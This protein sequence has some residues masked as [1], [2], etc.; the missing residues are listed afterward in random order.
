MAC[1]YQFKISS[2]DLGNLSRGVDGI[3]SLD[4]LLSAAPGFIEKSGEVYSYTDQ[5]QNDQRW[6]STVHL[7]PDG[8]CLS[9]YQRN[10]DSFDQKLMRF[11]MQE[12]LNRC[13]RLE[14]EDA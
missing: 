13:G 14:V 3:D 7:T 9:I 10:T 4:K 8:F 5:S 2:Q 11:L 6:L 12:L 1:E